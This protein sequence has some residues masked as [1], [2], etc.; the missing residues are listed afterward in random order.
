MMAGQRQAIRYIYIYIYLAH[1]HWTQNVYCKVM[2]CEIKQSE[3][4]V[5]LIS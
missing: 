1:A 2:K 3:R 5:S 4:F